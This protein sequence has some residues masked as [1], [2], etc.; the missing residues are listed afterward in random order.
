MRKNTLLFVVLGLILVLFGG[1]FFLSLDAKPTVELVEKVFPD[2][3]FP[4]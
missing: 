3:Q 2:E 4:R 1:A